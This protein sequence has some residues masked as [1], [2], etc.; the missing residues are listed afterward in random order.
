MKMGNQTICR[1]DDYRRSFWEAF[2]NYHMGVTAE[3]IVE[4]KGITREDQDV[5]S[6]ESQ[7][8]A[9]AAIGDRR[10]KDEI[11]PVVIPQRKGRS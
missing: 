5:S 8:R 3:N 9:Q 7:R 11:V 6:V 4:Q 2:N 1:R 10:F